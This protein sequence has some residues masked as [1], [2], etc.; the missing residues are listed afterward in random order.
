MIVFATLF[1]VA[2]VVEIEYVVGE[3]ARGQAAWLPT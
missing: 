2:F 1:V 3:K